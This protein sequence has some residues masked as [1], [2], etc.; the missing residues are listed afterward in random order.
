MATA[1][2]AARSNNSTHKEI[3]TNK[4]INNDNARLN[5]NGVNRI[6]S[7]AYKINNDDS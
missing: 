2:Q 4:L 3:S 6:N 5:S 1:N 7:D